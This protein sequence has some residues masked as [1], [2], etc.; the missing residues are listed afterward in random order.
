[1]KIRKFQIQHYR[2]LRE[3]TIYP[4][5]ILALVGRNN[6]GKSNVLKAHRLFFD[7]T[8]RGVSDETFYNHD[9]NSPIRIVA[10]FDDLSDWEM[11]QF[12]PWMD[13]KTLTVGRQIRCVGEGS[14]EISTL[15]VKRV[16]DCEWLDEEVIS[17]EKIKEWWGNKETLKIGALD[18]GALLGDKQPK[19][20]EWKT[21]AAEFIKQHAQEI[22]LIEKEIENPKGYPGVLKGALPEFLFVPAVRDVTDEATVS[23]TSPFGLLIN[24]VLEKISGEQKDLISGRLKEIERLLNR[25]TE[26]RIAE[27]QQ[28]ENRL[29][30][31]M[32]ELMDCDI[33][34]EMGLPQ[35]KEV[36]RETKVYANDGLRTTIE[37]KGHGLQRSMIFT[38][39][40]AYAEI[41]HLQKA[42]EQAEQRSTVFAIEEPELYLHP[43]FQRTLMGVF[44]QISSGRDQV[45]YST[46]SSLFIDI[47]SFD[48][49]C[50][51]RRPSDA[52]GFFSSPTQLLV[53][54]LIEDL[55]VRKGIDVTEVGIREQ[56]ANVFNPMINEGF[57]ADKVVIVEG[58][59]ELYSLPIYSQLLSYDLDRNNVAVVHGD[60]KGQM[61]R[62]L[63]IFN[64]FEI[65]TYL[66]FD[67]DKANSDAEVKRKTK[68]LLSL[69]G[70]PID[71]IGE[72][73]T[74]I[75]DTFAVLEENYETSMR[76]EVQDY[77]EMIAEAAEVLG[78]V[79][80][81]LRQRWIAR[82]IAGKASDGD[83]PEVV[84]P[85]TIRGIVEKVKQLSFTG[86]ILQTVQISK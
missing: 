85:E 12:G 45:F 61:D 64:G 73:Q 77:E 25:G 1:M 82:K 29:N 5:D 72:L 3:A 84:V 51:M 36:F 76:A 66:W 6:S 21:K 62:L 41:A 40:R 7:G 35:L 17:G 56:Y 26:G 38:I 14:Y 30:K 53:K 28:V 83:A 20:G 16:P 8:V 54:Q 44:R 39:L 27:I 74:T 31:L 65:P 34:I 60:G 49:I 70:S 71:D 4:S 55:K 67:G 22:P 32:S 59:S 2:S 19:V 81:P 75:S 63:R 79:G 68:E 9:T 43:Q 86:T 48:D 18:F 58:P 11:K 47:A 69:M 23:K 42:G 37:T 57:F 80:K 52:H 78:P 10:T 13:N 33:E 46:Q 24:S 15:A 50:I